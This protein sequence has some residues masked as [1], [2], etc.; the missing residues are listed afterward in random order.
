MKDKNIWG[1]KHKKKSKKKDTSLDDAVKLG[2]TLA[3]ASLALGIG[4]KILGD[5]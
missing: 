1:F 4:T 2:V 3:T 5:L